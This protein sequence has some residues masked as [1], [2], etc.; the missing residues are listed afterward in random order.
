[1]AF[2][3][4]PKTEGFFY[5]ISI[6][7]TTNGGAS[8]SLDFEIK[9]KRFSRSKLKALSK[10]YDELNGLDDEIDPLERDVDYIFEIAEDWRGILDSNKENIPFEREY[11]TTVIDEF[12]SSAG[13]IVKAFFEAT[14]GGG[15]KA[16]NS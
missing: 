4:A 13:A 2:V 9:F 15:A 12:P 5:G 11:V 3:L 16:K 1:M 7:V 14:L 8:R 10:V 6:P